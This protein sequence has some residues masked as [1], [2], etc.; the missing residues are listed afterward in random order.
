MITSPPYLDVTSFEEDQWLRLWFLGGP[1]HPTYNKISK[2]DRHGSPTAYWR[3]ITDMWR[4]LGLVLAPKADIVVRLGG[5]GFTP[6]HLVEALTAS[7][8]VSKRPVRLISHETTTI[9][10]RQ[11]DAFRPGSKGCKFEVDCYLRM[12]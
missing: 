2:D 12:I 7:G 4:T 8:A 9:K 6:E 5:K 3:M 1:P 10:N 11:T